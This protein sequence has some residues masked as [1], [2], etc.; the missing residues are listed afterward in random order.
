MQI[1]LQ[2]LQFFA[3]HGLHKEE[4]ILGNWFVV[5]IM[6]DISL[7]STQNVSLED[8]VDYSSIFKVVQQLMQQPTPLLENLVSQI[9]HQIL[10]QFLLVQNV[11]ISIYKQNP[12]IANFIGNVGV[13][14]TLKR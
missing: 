12:P 7:P 11:Q 14:Y 2:N 10:A 8:T 6:A 9:A 3:H 5:N 13:S 4:Q 1:H